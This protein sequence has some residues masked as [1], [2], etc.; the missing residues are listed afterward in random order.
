[1][2]WKHKTLW[3]GSAMLLGLGITG[4]AMAD[5]IGDL[6]VSV[7]VNDVGTEMTA[8]LDS[9]S[10]GAD[11]GTVDVEA[12]GDL[13]T[14]VVE[15]DA[16]TFDVVYSDDTKLI[17]PGSYVNI[18]LG[19]GSVPNAF[20]ALDPL[21]LVAFDGS[22]SAN[23]QIPGRYL[24]I[25]GMINPQQEKFTDVNGVF[26][27][28]IWS[29]S[30]KG[31]VPRAAGSTTTGDPIYKVGDIGGTFGPTN[32][33]LCHVTDDDDVVAWDTI[34]CGANDFGETGGASHRIAYI[35]PGSGF[36]SATHTIEL[37]LQVPAG[38][39]PGTYTGVLTVEQVA[40]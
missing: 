11:F 23:F 19:D 18:K 4:P 26:S 10:S 15:D 33:S 24:T 28:P 37:D 39:Y 17:R 22:S 1:M 5:E 25:S 32:A 16:V 6:P 29:N 34:N 9:G 40:A 12:A 2:N 27:D 21:D 35:L 20:L 8:S 30:G 36:V 13:G 38:V 31:R 7:T 3:L 14:G